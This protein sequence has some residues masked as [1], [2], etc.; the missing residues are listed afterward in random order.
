MRE[1]RKTHPMTEEQRRKDI[2]RS[3]A[4][5]YLRRGKIT[6]EPCRVCGGPAEMH[7]PDYDKPYEVDWLCRKCHL[8]EHA[9]LGLGSGVDAGHPEH[10]AAGPSWDMG[11]R[12]S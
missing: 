10:P 1:W 12:E 6:R 11:G 7:H 8:E 4:G 9:T 2:A 3:K 5:V